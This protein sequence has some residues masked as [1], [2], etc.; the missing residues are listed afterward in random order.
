MVALLG[1]DTDDA[2]AIRSMILRP[3]GG[4]LGALRADTLAGWTATSTASRVAVRSARSVTTSRPGAHPG[5]AR[6]VRV[7]ARRGPLVAAVE[8][9]LAEP[10]TTA[11]AIELDGAVIGWIQ[12]QAEEEPDYRRV[13]RHLP[14]PGHRATGRVARVR[15]LADTSHRAR[16]PPHRDRPRRRQ[17][18]RHPL[19]EGGVPAG[20]DPPLGAGLTAWHGAL[21]MDLLAEELAAEP[22]DQAL[23]RS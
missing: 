14:R 19:F 16:A 8:E 9:D 5:N 20:R 1:A 11:Y 21:L 7:L 13:D 17:P 15:A 23:D 3:D 6:G 18:R 10:G 4:E 12:W 2:A 22:D